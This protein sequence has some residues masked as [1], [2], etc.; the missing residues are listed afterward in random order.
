MLKINFEDVCVREISR[1]VK[2]LISKKLTFNQLSLANKYWLYIYKQ[3]YIP[4]TSHL[5]FRYLTETEV[6]L[7]YFRVH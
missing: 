4:C 2:T 3:A 1:S 5:S 6:N 7:Q